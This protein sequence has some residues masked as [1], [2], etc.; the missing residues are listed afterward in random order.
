MSAEEETPEIAYAEA[1]AAP[2]APEV[3]Q[4]GDHE[5]MPA[6]NVTE[7]GAGT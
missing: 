1:P 3:P 6:D 4:D 5:E 2:E 7:A